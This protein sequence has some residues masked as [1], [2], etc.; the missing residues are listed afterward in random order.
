MNWSEVPEE[1][2]CSLFGDIAGQKSRR[3]QTQNDKSPKGTNQKSSRKEDEDAYSPTGQGGKGQGPN[4]VRYLPRDDQAGSAKC[5]VRMWEA[6]PQLV[7][8]A[9]EHV[10]NV[11]ETAGVFCAETP[12]CGFQDA[13]HQACATVEG[14]QVAPARREVPSRRNHGEYL[15]L[16]EGA[17]PEITRQR[18]VLQHMWETSARRREL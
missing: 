9:S 7:C 8:D 12:C 3:R 4:Q 13:S 2:G 6:V 18:I 1:T 15:S 16:D 14:R 11:R 17:D 10:P 5:P